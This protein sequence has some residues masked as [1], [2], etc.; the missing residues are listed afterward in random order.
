MVT[1]PRL[2]IANTNSRGTEFH[3]LS[4]DQVNQLGKPTMGRG[5]APAVMWGTWH[6]ESTLVCLEGG[7]GEGGIW[8]KHA[9]STI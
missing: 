8:M 9:A 7:P 2:L 1:V 3:W 5:D 6:C 4:R